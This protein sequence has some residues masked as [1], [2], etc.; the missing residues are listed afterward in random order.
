MKIKSLMLAAL[1]SLSPM[2]QAAPEMAV[3]DWQAALLAS[4]KVKSAFERIEQELAGDKTKVRQLAEEAKALQERMQKD[5]AIM[6]D[7]EKR[8]LNQQIQEKAQEYQFLVSRLQQAQR[9]RRQEVM[10]Q[11]KPHLDEAIQRLIKERK[12]DLLLDRQ[13]A[14]FVVPQYDITQEVVDQLNKLAK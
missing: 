3:L 14:T 7:A 13:A 8:K 2:V 1:I 6:G 5:G 9:E 12:L 4:D 10:R 11:A